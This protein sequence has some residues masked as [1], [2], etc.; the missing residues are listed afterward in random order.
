MGRQYNIELNELAS[1]YKWAI[2]QD[3][4]SIKRALEASVDLP[5]IAIGSGGSLSV[6]L[7][8]ANAHTRRFSKLSRAITPLELPTIFPS[9]GNAAIWMFSA[10]GRNIDIQRAFRHSVIN[11]PRQLSF[12]CF[13]RASPLSRIA[14]KHQWVENLV[15]DPIVSRD[16]FLATNSLLCFY[17]LIA[18]A[19]LE[20]DG[21]GEFLPNS[22]AEVLMRAD[23]KLSS[24]KKSFAKL[25]K[26]ETFVVLH[27][28]STQSAAI[29]FESR[30]TEAALGSV[31]IAD[32]RNF[33]HGRHHWLA[34][35]GNTSAVIAFYDSGETELAKQTLNLL[36]SDIP[37]LPIEI[38]GTGFTV[39][40]C[41]LI[42][43]M[44]IADWMG[45]A[46][47]INPGGPGVPLFGRKLYRLRTPTNHVTRQ[48]RDGAAIERK[49][50][51]KCIG[52]HDNR[53]RNE[54]FA[55]LKAFRSRLKRARYSYL[56]SDYDGTL[57][58]T[59]YKTKPPTPEI[60]KE[61]THLLEG[62]IILGI[63]TG[64][65]DS[66][67]ADLRTCL[68]KKWWENIWIGY[69][70][71]AQIG[72]LDD[73]AFPNPS[74]SPR[75]ELERVYERLN[76][77]NEVG[78]FARVRVGKDQISIDPGPRIATEKAM[79]IAE[80]AILEEGRED[81]VFLRSGHSVDIVH[82]ST[83]KLNLVK[84]LY[85]TIQRS[86]EIL[87]LGDRGR[88][89]GNDFELLSTDFSL[90]VDEVSPASSSCW[91][92]APPGVRGPQAT[93]FYLRK[94]EVFYGT[95]EARFFRLKGV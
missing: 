84:H 60:V 90:S 58:D 65:G 89:P 54:S 53:S 52:E 47:N 4:S 19:Y 32:F 21:S 44:N 34:K 74:K 16:G 94:L 76:A 93:L 62:G 46:K 11:E 85:N 23:S 86:G 7:E 40:I 36:P 68:D 20:L 73:D 13:D 3:V 9:D 70:N 88:W 5:V 55:E 56:V 25:D 43:S 67:R 15:F 80:Q 2:Q 35:Q 92:L 31:Q 27:G 77:L 17:V 8:T 18:R 37:R 75:P 72:R 61:L 1:T 50:A 26:K 10:G 79:E 66:V 63:A 64:R 69:Y 24:L 12:L 57:V 6:A 39:A 71:C 33:A 78:I 49:C 38:D 59:R 45:Q 87:T 48:T 14:K 95:G 81:I 30:F 42:I 83:S 91:N 82:K 51:A 22:L 28:N 29:D 41:S